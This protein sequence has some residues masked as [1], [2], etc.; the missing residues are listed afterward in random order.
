MCVKVLDVSTTDIF[1]FPKK[2]MDVRGFSSLGVVL[3]LIIAFLFFK[4]RKYT[5]KCGEKKL[6]KFSSNHRR[7]CKNL[8]FHCMYMK[9]SKHEKENMIKIKRNMIE[10]KGFCRKCD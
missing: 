10:L 2:E 6:L 7:N 8:K 3:F 1:V 4:K 9:T 5:L